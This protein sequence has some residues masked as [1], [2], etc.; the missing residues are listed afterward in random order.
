M[1]SL[2]DG[3]SG[4]L[5]TV[6]RGDTLRVDSPI[7]E[8]SEL[9][10]N[11]YAVS[12]LRSGEGDRTFG[13]KICIGVARFSFRPDCVVPRTGSWLVTAL[14]TP[15]RAVTFTTVIPHASRI[16]TRQPSC[17]IATASLL[18]LRVPQLAAGYLCA[19]GREYFKLDVRRARSKMVFTW[20]NDNFDEGYSYGRA[21]PVHLQAGHQLWLGCRPGRA[22]PRRRWI[23]S[24]NCPSGG[25]GNRTRVRDRAKSGVYERSRRSSLIFRS[26]RRPGCGK[27][28]PRVSPKCPGSH[29]HRVSLLSDSG[30][31]AAGERGPE[32]RR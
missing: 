17:D 27:P 25:G 6:A 32:P 11:V 28:A 14:G 13:V 18:P 26:P 16:Y 21:G 15:G 9:D 5:L 2:G 20:A 4:Y 10:V 23:S 8:E 24:K 3:G 7:T 29:G 31:P 30:G 19:G 12:A 22:P 1:V